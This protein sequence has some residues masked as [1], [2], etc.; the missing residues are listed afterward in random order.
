MLKTLRR[1]A[2]ATAPSRRSRPSPVARR[3][4]A[5]QARPDPEADPDAAARTP[6]LTESSIP[7]R[8]RLARATRAGIWTCVRVVRGRL[9]IDYCDDGELARATPAEPVWIPPDVRHRLVPDGWV[10][11]YLEYY[12]ADDDQAGSARRSRTSSIRS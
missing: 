3:G 10:R 2:S 4:Q 9:D 5:L 11:F 7:R 1:P 12:Q 6:V 8:F